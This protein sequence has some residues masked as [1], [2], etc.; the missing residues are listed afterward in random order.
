MD[1]RHPGIQSIC[2]YV[3]IYIS[4]TLPGQKVCLTLVKCK[5]NVNNLLQVS[6]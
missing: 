2:M 1:T 6:S 5:Y 4:Y 3:Y